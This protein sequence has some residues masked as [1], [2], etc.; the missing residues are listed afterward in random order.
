MRKYRVEYIIFQNFKKNNYATPQKTCTSSPHSYDSYRESG[1]L[2]DEELTVKSHLCRKSKKSE[3]ARKFVLSQTTRSESRKEADG[4]SGQKY[5][6]YYYEYGGGS[7]DSRD[8]S[9]KTPPS[10][11]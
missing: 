1:S 7:I 4:G 8:K 2:S 6:D 5:R 3:I 10:K 11:I 9:Y